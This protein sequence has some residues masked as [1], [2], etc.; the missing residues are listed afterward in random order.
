MNDNYDLAKWL[1]DEMTDEEL[2]KFQS[3]PDYSTFEK[4]KNY[5]SQLET[6]NFNEDE[7]LHTILSTKK[8]NTKVVSIFNS[9]YF[10]IAAILIIALGILLSY[11][12]FS[13]TNVEAH[14]ASKTNFLLPDNSEVILNADSKIE[15]K[16][17]NWETNRNLNLKGEAYF[18]VAKGQKFTVHTNLGDVSVLGTQFNVKSRNNRFDVTCYE[19]KVKVTFTN[20]EI[21]LT[22]GKTI[23]IANNQLIIDG[24]SNDEN[25]VWMNNQIGFDKENLSN[26]IE[27]IKRNYNVS[28]IENNK[29]TEQLFTGK[30]PANNLNVAL[31][32]I[33]SSYHLKI[34]KINPT[35][36][37]FEE[38]N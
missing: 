10:K 3:H 28:I 20:K 15:Y 21:I 5:S 25:P 27:E 16:K 1:N 31:E 13:T 34:K 38:T 32:I 17:W 24:N 35:S 37:S 36:Y 11:Q 26:I 4:I 29:K 8:E 22:K 2:K 18:K 9:A 7:M 23:S 6:S 30:L 12:M 19:G 33:A 14:L